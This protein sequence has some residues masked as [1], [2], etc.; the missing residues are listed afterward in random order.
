MATCV[1]RESPKESSETRESQDKMRKAFRRADSD[2]KGRIPCDQ[3]STAA[4]AAGIDPTE[5]ELDELFQH[6]D[7]TADNGI[8]FDEF[9]DMMAYLE[10]GSEKDYEETLRKAFK[11]VQILNVVL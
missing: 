2:L 6:F 7:K 5:D 8:N 1:E 11:W 10:D 4:Q 3:F 9:V